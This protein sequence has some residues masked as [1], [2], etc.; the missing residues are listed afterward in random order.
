MRPVT[1]REIELDTAVLD[2]TEDVDKLLLR[3]SDGSRERVASV[4]TTSC[5]VQA[6]GLPFVSPLS[7]I[8]DDEWLES[9]WLKRGGAFVEFP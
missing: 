5:S 4:L 2:G 6:L 8:V 1:Y 7:D 9:V 3:V